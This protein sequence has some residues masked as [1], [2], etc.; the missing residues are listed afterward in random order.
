MKIRTV[1]EIVSD[2]GGPE[3]ISAASLKLEKKRRITEKGVYSWHR[4][5]IPQKHW[6]L[7]MPLAGTNERELFAANI[8]L[9]KPSKPAASVAA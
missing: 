9:S 5:G 1:R 8:R 4:I 3:R 6:P 7:I 2:A